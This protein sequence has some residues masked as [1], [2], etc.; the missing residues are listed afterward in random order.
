MESD[1]ENE[2]TEALSRVSI[3]TGDNLLGF[4]IDMDYGLLYAAHS[5]IPIV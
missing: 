1:I 3:S 2:I 5:K 4:Q